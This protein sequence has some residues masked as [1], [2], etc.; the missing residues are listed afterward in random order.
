MLGLWCLALAACSSEKTIET[1]RG[2]VTVRENS[3]GVEVTSHDG[4]LTIQGNEKWGHISIKTDDGEDI[5]VAYNRDSLAADF[6]ADVP[7]YS[8]SKITMSQVL[9]GKSAVCSLA[10]QDDTGTIARFYRKQLP[11]NGWDLKDEMQFG[12]MVL[13]QGKKR[14]SDLTVSILKKDRQTAVTLAVTEQKK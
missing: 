11:E 2:N 1:P 7:V 14:G 8:R 3:D 12:D 9:K 4:S 13:M 6:P 5:E 10:S